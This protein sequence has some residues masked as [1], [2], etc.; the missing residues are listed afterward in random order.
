MLHKALLCLF[1]VTR[2]TEE[3]VMNYVEEILQAILI[4]L[5]VANFLINIGRGSKAIEL[6]NESLVLLNHKALN[7]TKQL[8]QFIYKEIYGTMFNAYRRVSDHTNALACGRKLLAI[9]QEC[10]DTVQ[11]G[12]LSIALAQIC[13][14]QRMY[15]E[16]KEL[17]ERAIPLMRTTGN[18]RAEAISYGGLGKL[19]T[20][21]CKYVKAKKYYEKA[22][23]ISIEI[24]DR[25]GEAAYYGN[26][27][28]VFES[29]GEY[30]KAK[31]YLEK[32]LAI[33][34][35]IGDRKGEATWY[36]HLGGVFSLSMNTSRL[37]NFT[38]NHLRST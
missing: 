29:L 12:T 28:R 20:A 10:G 21:A 2:I 13:E 19:F 8:G 38:R 27:G 33:S 4:G 3:S 15:A 14:R 24:G 22:L 17:Y 31:E 9:H 6:C 36:G 34:I 32:A 18:R 30:V 11:E 5:A 16:A 37:I 25:E 35:E 7:I 1:P 26:L 23:A